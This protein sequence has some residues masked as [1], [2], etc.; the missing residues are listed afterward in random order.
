MR[1]VS[2]E[3]RCVWEHVGPLQHSGWDVLITWCV[4]YCP[5]PVWTFAFWL[6]MDIVCFNH[7]VGTTRRPHPY[8]IFTTWCLWFKCHCVSWMEHVL[9]LQ[10][11]SGILSL[12][13]PLILEH[14]LQHQVRCSRRLKTTFESLFQFIV[15]SGP[16]VFHSWWLILVRGFCQKSSFT[17]VGCCGA[18][19]I[20]WVMSEDFLPLLLLQVVYFNSY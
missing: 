18:F 14:E 13:V 12:L 11:K 1:A 6:D 5:S 2:G 20:S 9:T 17:L 15:T 7:R 19:C 4:V 16:S 10:L 3:D 8:L